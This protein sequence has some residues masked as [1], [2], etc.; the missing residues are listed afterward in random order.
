MLVL[1]LRHSY[2]AP[3][4]MVST[5]C[6]TRCW[7][8]DYGTATVP[9]AL[10]AN[11]FLHLTVVRGL[12]HSYGAP[13]RSEQN[14]PAPDVGARATAQLRCAFA[15]GVYSFLHLMLVQELRHSYGAPSR[16]VSTASCTR[17]WFKS[18]GTATVRLRA[19]CLQL[20]APYVGAWATAQLRCAFALGVYSFLYLTMVL[21]LR[22]NYDAPSRSLPT[23]SC[24]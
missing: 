2:G 8:L 24:T 23:A 4:R 22:H 11:S 3:S 9:F 13:S 7:C 15:L 17:C 20:P 18:Y 16:S 21:E 12:R 10:V 5:A 14:I 19:W 6:C 1:R